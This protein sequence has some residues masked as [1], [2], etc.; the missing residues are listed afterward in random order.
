MR[1]EAELGWHRARPR[2]IPLPC[3]DHLLPPADS[4]QLAVPSRCACAFSPCVC[5][6][7]CCP[8]QGASW[9]WRWFRQCQAGV[10]LVRPGGGGPFTSWKLPEL[11]LSP[12]PAPPEQ[13]SRAQCP[14]PKRGH[15]ALPAPAFGSLAAFPIRAESPEQVPRAWP[16]LER[17][18]SSLC[19][20]SLGLRPLHSP[21]PRP[22][23][24]PAA[25]PRREP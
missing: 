3:P 22:A 7:V 15:Q 2:S 14:A 21:F 6:S 13:N 25:S 9:C 23:S 12:S 19:C 10:D 5:V 20:N 4:P 11:C 8:S 16:C 1:S 24:V 18:R 17:N